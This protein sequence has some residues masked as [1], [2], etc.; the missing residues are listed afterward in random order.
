MALSFSAWDHLLGCRPVRAMFARKPFL[1]RLLPPT[2]DA[3]EQDNQEWG[4]EQ[5][6][7][8]H[9][10][11]SLPS[12]LS[13]LFLLSPSPPRSFS[14]SSSLHHFA[15]QNHPPHLLEINPHP[16]LSPPTLDLSEAIVP[17]LPAPDLKFDNTGTV[18]SNSVPAARRTPT[19][20]RRGRSKGRRPGPEAGAVIGRCRP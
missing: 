17:E 6:S 13:A 12:L 10:S 8:L 4:S 20:R 9:N 3:D 18:T 19:V 14:P 11:T 16:P 7:N 5:G 1:R 15:L 2:S